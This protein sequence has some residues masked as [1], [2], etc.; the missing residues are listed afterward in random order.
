MIEYRRDIDGLRALAV[1]AV[2]FYHADHRLVPGGY[3]GVD[4]FFVI[5]GFLITSMILKDHAA[6]V[7]S[8]AQFWE[9]RVR[10][11]LPAMMVMMAA[12]VLA[13]LVILFPPDLQRFGAELLAQSFFSSNILF[14][15]QS[16]YFDLQSSFRPLLHTW[17]L[18]VEEQFYLLFPLVM[19]MG[20]KVSRRCLMLWLCG[21]LVVSYVLCILGGIYDPVPSFYLLPMRSWEFLIGALLPFIPRIVFSRF[22]HEVLSVAALG[23][24][25]Y[26]FFFQGNY[27]T[28][29]WA[30]MALP[31]VAT[32]VLLWL[33]PPQP[34]LVERVLSLPPVQGTGVI[35]YSLYLWHWPIFTYATYIL[36]RP[37]HLN[38]TFGL[39]GLIF[40]LAGFSWVLLEQPIRQKKLLPGRA[41]I[42]RIALVGALAFALFG[43]TLYFSD[44]W[45]QRFS[46]AVNAYAAATAETGKYTQTCA[47]SPTYTL[48]TDNVCMVGPHDAAPQFLVF[49]DSFADAQ[50]PALQQ[51]AELH[52]RAGLLASHNACPPLF[53]V[54]RPNQSKLYHCRAFNDRMKTLIEKSGVRTVM[55]VARWPAY[56][57][58]YMLS[59]DDTNHRWTPEESSAIFMRAF[60]TTVADLQR[61]GITVWIVQAPPEY[62]FDVPRRM[63][64]TTRLGGDVTFIGQSLADYKVSQVSFEKALAGTTGVRL[65]SFTDTLCR[66]DLWCRAEL[67]GASLY[68]DTHHLSEGGAL[69]MAPQFEDFFKSLK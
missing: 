10:R 45:P 54:D 47:R 68:R 51:A 53:G 58:L 18:A 62:P 22:E 28:N 6:G 60:Q 5:S 57:T 41:Q 30:I 3:A 12:T 11:I 9:R 38:E 27:T 66:E 64:V 20:L 17:S 24:I 16:G 65:I 19:I 42:F 55:L 59:D 2:I 56:G 40:V 1:L 43:G 50:F 29:L 4:V 23:G 32:A 69:L 21:L 36:V 48:P 52:G 63:A 26:T 61:Q 14:A 39:L 7:F 46:P 37:L 44:G 35:S 15:A 33:R 8:L 25:L 34:T 49:G 31:C 67:E 13:A